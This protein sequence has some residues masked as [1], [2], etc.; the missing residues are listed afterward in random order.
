MDTDEIRMR[1]AH[2]LREAIEVRGVTVLD[3]ATRAKVGRPHL[4]KV[5]AGGTAASVDYIAKLATVLDIDPSDLLAA[6]PITRRT[7]RMK[8]SE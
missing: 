7:K 4:Y 2:R 6:K 8:A 1:L 5:L 3:L